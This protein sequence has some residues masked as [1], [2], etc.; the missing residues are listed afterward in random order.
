MSKIFVQIASYR[1]SQ[2]LP[3]LRDL[4][5]KASRADQLRFGICWQRDET[6]SIEEF[7][8]DRRCRVIEIDYRDARGACWARQQT[9]SLYEDE[10]YTLQ[11][12]SHHRFVQGWDD[13]LLAMVKLTKSEKPIL[14]SY[15]PA[16]DPSDTSGVFTQQPWALKFHRFTPDGIVFF[17]PEPIADWENL[18]RPLPARF[19]SA[20]FAFAHGAFCREVPYDPNYYFHGEEI[21]MAVRAFTHGYDLFYPH[22][23]ILWHEYTRN[24]RPKHWDDHTLEK[25]VPMPWTTRN[26]ETFTRNRILFGMEDGDVDFGPY[27]FGNVRTLKEYE[28][29]AGVNFRLRRVQPYT[30]LNEPPPNPDVYASDDEWIA[31]CVK[32]FWTCIRLPA[33]AV[34]RD[35]D[36]DFWYVGVH[37]DFD[38]EIDRQDLG[39]DDLPSILAKPRIEFIHRYRAE[40]EAQSWTVWPHSRSRGWLEKITRPIQP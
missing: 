8:R 15:A 28:Q 1:D 29:F 24:Y 30:Y 13:A 18:A 39:S 7:A 26:E 6:E 22:R 11:I 14:T 16:F 4:I 34:E 20:H 36:Y 21:S 38:G 3:T 9:Q 12:D 2:L 33:E 35:A 10:D 37:D 31:R 27:G 5:A 32:D 25:G 19:F 40:R 17:M 23:T